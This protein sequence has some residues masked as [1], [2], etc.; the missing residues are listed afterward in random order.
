YQNKERI[1]LIIDELGRRGS[2]FTKD[3]TKGIETFVEVLRS[4]SYV[5][6]NNKEVN[7]LYER[8]FQD[9]CLPALKAIAKNPNF[10]LGTD[11]QDA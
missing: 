5:G 8:S 11:K 1:Q 7:Y 4:V 2:T 9:K 10:K 3:D 6:F